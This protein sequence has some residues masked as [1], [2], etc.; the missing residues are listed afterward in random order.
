MFYFGASNSG[1]FE[2]FLHAGQD[3]YYGIQGMERSSLAK[4]VEAKAANVF[5][6]YNDE[7]ANRNDYSSIKKLLQ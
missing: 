5:S 7:S 2:E 6:V 1:I 3:D 4:E